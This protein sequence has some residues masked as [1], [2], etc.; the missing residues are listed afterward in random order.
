MH[1]LV[2][3]VSSVSV[4]VASCYR[5]EILTVFLVILPS[6]HCLSSTLPL[7]YSSSHLTNSHEAPDHGR[8]RWNHLRRQI[9]DLRMWIRYRFFLLHGTLSH[10]LYLLPAFLNN[11]RS[12]LLQTE[13][14]KGMSLEQAGA[15][16]NKEIANE[17]CLPP[18]KLHC[19]SESTSISILF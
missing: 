4:V 3:M 7:F 1:L 11:S 6:L 13:R 10:L 2:V 17:L 19:S 12:L 9:Q 15:I 14:V 8:R 18:V 5:L 16:T